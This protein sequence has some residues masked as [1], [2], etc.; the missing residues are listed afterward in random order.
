MKIHL[1]LLLLAL[2][3]VAAP[4]VFTDIKGRPL[5]AELVKTSATKVWLKLDSGKTSSVSK[6]NFSEGDQA[7]I[8]KWEA[9]R[10]PNMRVEPNFTRGISKDG[11]DGFFYD[12]SRIQ[13]FNLAVELSNQSSTKDLEETEVI[14]YLVGKST[15]DRS[16]KVL[17]RQVAQL[18]IPAKETKTITF[19]EIANHYR[20]GQSYQTGHKGLGYV[21]LVQRKRDGRRV[22]LSSPTVSLKDSVENIIL[23]KSGDV[24]DSNFIKLPKNAVVG[25]DGKKKSDSIIIR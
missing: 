20:D 14:Y 10:L 15:E 24:T 23:L 19:K 6:A 5:S 7:Y 25:E 4:R 12:S 3:L 13:K 22:Y 8:A 2:P 1:L 21:L 18:E 16:F 9:D 17:A 11:N